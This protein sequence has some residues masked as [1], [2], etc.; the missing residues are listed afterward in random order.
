[1]KIRAL[2][3][4]TIRDAETG[5]LTSIAHNGIAEI[6]N[7]LGAKLITDGLAEEYTLISPTGSVNITAN[8]VV[9]VTAYANANVL[10]EPTVE[11]KVNPVAADV[12][13]LGKLAGELQDNVVVNDGAISG[14]LKYVTEYTGFSGDESMQ[15]GNYLAI[16]AEAFGGATITVELINGTVGHPVTLD[17]DGM[18]VLR[19]TDIATQSVEV[20]A[21]KGNVSEKATYTLTGL[22]LEDNV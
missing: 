17:A 8:G 12:D 18:I 3:A 2:K 7:T 20:I 16:K 5:A 4:F 9:D 13:L 15:S 14:T 19:I 21:T 6:D 1:M 11:L 10:V 22:T